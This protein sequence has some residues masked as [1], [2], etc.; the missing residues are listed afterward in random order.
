MIEKKILKSLRAV[1]G[2][3]NVYT[4]KSDKITHSYDATQKSYLPDVVVYAESS[5]QVSEIVKL[6]NDHLIPILARGAGSGFTGG[7]LPV[8]GGIVLVLTKMDRILSID[9]DNL[10]E[11]VIEISKKEIKKR[12][13][14]IKEK[15]LQKRDE[16]IG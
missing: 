2:K 10:I 13:S 8:R 1:V 15:E 6:A 14:E 3:D 9:A 4:D 11:E 16:V 7:S 5:G 12:N